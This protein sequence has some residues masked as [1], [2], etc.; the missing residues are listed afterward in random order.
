MNLAGLCLRAGAWSRSF[1]S[2]AII[3]GMIM[4]LMLGLH[5]EFHYQHQLWQQCKQVSQLKWGPQ[6]LFGLRHSFLMI[7]LVLKQRNPH[8][9]YLLKTV[10]LPLA[11]KLGCATKMCI[12]T[13]WENPKVSVSVFFSSNSF[14]HVW[15]LCPVHSCCAW[16]H[17]FSEFPHPGCDD[18]VWLQLVQLRFH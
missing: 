11:G 14:F 9:G 12:Q 7:S 5:W 3:L 13:F 16:P 8:L 18:A 4:N 10:F 15:A 6:H 17:S 1:T 2:G